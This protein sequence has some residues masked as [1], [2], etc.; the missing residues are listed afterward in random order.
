[1]VES[2]PDAVESALEKM[3]PFLTNVTFGGM[4]GYTTGYA[5][6]KISKAVAFFVGVTFVALQTGVYCGYIDVDWLKIKDTAF[7]KADAVRLQVCLRKSAAFIH[8]LFHAHSLFVSSDSRIRTA[9]SQPTTS[10]ITG[11]SSRES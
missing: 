1:M 11:A 7:Q 10:S 3:T 4:M 2:K 5:M 9:S 8:A 6:K